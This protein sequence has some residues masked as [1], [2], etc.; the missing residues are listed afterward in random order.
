MA[1]LGILVAEGAAVFGLAGVA[2]CA[3]KAYSSRLMTKGAVS[4]TAADFFKKSLRLDFV[5]ISGL[6]LDPMRPFLLRIGAK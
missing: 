2:A 3:P 5:F 6:A 1:P 4:V